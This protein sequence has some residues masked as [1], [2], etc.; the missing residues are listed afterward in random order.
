MVY[1]IFWQRDM[2]VNIY[3]RHDSSGI[4]I[5]KQTIG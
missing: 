1:M 2:H 5:R 3:I 4:S